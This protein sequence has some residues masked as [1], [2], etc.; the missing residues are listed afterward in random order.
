MPPSLRYRN[1]Y[2]AGKISDFFISNVSNGNRIASCRFS[3]DSQRS[4]VID[5]SS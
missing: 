4:D 5:H 1:G 2:M 3:C